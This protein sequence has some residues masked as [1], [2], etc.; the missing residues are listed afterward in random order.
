MSVILKALQSSKDEP[1]NTE[2]PSEET[3]TDDGVYF[4]SKDVFV[5]KTLPSNGSPKARF[6][7]IALLLSGGL[8]LVLSYLGTY[9]FLQNKTVSNTIPNT[10]EYVDNTPAPNQAKTPAPLVKTTTPDLDTKDLTQEAQ[11]AFENKNYDESLAL[12]KKALEQTPEDFNLHNNLGLLY[13]KKGLYSSA[14][15]SFQKALELNDS[16]AVCFNNFGLL[17]TH[18]G[19]KVEAT[20]YFE[21]AIVS[22]T[23]YPDPYFNLAVLY[24]G[25]G[26]IGNAVNYYRQFVQLNPKKESDISL[27]VQSRIRILTGK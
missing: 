24:E 10:I 6:S 8:I 5:K 18:L 16:C 19:E 3:G 20:K 7:I 21:K 11:E 22:N 9:Y 13:L 26:D 25:S 14:S 23:T 15:S 2:T 17:K 1:E 27:N 12:Y 4:H